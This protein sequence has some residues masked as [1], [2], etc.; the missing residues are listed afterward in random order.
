MK[1]VK[2]RYE[3]SISR[4][5]FAIVGC[6]YGVILLMLLIA[7][8]YLIA[9]YSTNKLQEKYEI[10][11]EYKDI[12]N[13][14]IKAV[15]EITY[16]IYAQSES[17]RQLSQAK[18]ELEQYVAAYEIYNELQSRVNLK[19][20][21]DGF[22]LFYNYLDKAYYYLR[23]RVSGGE[24]SF[25]Q[26][27]QIKTF[28]QMQLKTEDVQP[29][30]PMITSNEN[31]VIFISSYQKNLAAVC[32]VYSM[33]EELEGLKNALGA[34]S[35]VILLDENRAYWNKDMAERYEIFD[36]LKEE[37]MSFWDKAPECMIYGRELSETGLWLCVA[38][39]NKIENYFG[40]LQIIMLILTVGSV[41]VVYFLIRFLYREYF[42]QVVLLTENMN[43]IRAGEGEFHGN[44]NSR[45][46]EI[47][48]INETLYA[49]I[50]EIEKQKIETY[51]RT[52]EKQ[53]AQLC[54]LQLQLRPH[55]FL[56]CLKSLNAMAVAR[57][58]EKAQELIMNIS[59][60]L[61][62]LMQNERKLVR[63][64][65]EIRFVKNY[66]D[67]QC[68]MSGHKIENN[69]EVQKEAEEC[70]VPP[71]CIQ[72]FV[73]NSVKYAISPI[74][75]PALK[76]N[77]QVD[78]LRTEEGN[79]LDIQI[80]DDGR[81]YSREILQE[82]NG[83]ELLGISSVG[84]NNLKRRLR[85]LYGEKAVYL[86]DNTSGAFSEIIIPAVREPQKNVSSLEKRE[87]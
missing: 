22:Y 13:S 12:I 10:V 71:L 83:E 39:P 26:A 52:I 59:F 80:E 49:M 76:I 47:R 34:D 14:N 86:F 61:R 25:D 68:N 17:F 81:G 48:E 37:Q 75:I 20:S 45:F 82:I 78:Y 84:I 23:P 70:F 32:S 62:Y 21:L 50:C 63:L 6:S 87:S 64:D 69:I 66:I 36:K 42:K 58:D 74:K 40:V 51:E 30:R 27:K 24:Y 72:T 56:N 11:E 31:G 5:V 38:L 16:N 57:E 29:V 35:E 44:T 9:D 77:I 46:K 4:S 33:T 67:L 1:R 28:I 79:V 15:E 41:A 19:Q 7:D 65:E 85:L 55:F 53:E 2:K 8:W 18:E 60:Y 43:L 73:E 3:W 54:Y